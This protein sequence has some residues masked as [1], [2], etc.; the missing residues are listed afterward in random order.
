MARN[1]D[2][3]EEKL[4]PSLI[5]KK[6]ARRRLVGALAFLS[7]VGLSLPFLLDPEPKSSPAEVQ[8]RVPAREP[9]ATAQTPSMA[10]PVIPNGPADISAPRDASVK[11]PARAEVKDEVAVVDVPKLEN[12]KVES[13]KPEPSKPEVAK[14]DA[15]KPDVKKEDAKKEDAKKEGAKKE[16]AKKDPIKKVESKKDDRKAAED[17]KS[18][19]VQIGAFS[20]EDSANEQLAKATRLGLK[21]YTEK[22]TRNNVAW[23][24]VRLGPF[25]AREQAEQA[26]AKLK[27]NGIDG[28]LVAP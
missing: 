4:D 1:T 18:Y 12:P 6:K 23:I 20:N 5:H 11:A 22:F 16:G 17:G 3:S 19:R 9:L 13:A 2:T 25:G 15:K 28:A 7:A 27:L 8:I 14:P 21:A 10:P 26:L 24:R